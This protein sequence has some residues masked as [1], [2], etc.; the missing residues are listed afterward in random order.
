MSLRPLTLVGMII[1]IV[2]GIALGVLVH[3]RVPHEPSPAAD[4]LD[5]VLRQVA[6]NYVEEV[7]EEELLERAIEGMMQ[8]LDRHS[9]YL[10]RDSVESLEATT[11]GQFGGIGIELGFVDGHYTIISPMDFTPAARVGLRSGDRITH[12]EGDTVT[13]MKMPALVERLRGE[14][15]SAVKLTIEREGY[16]GREFEIEREVIRVA[17]VNTRLLEPGYGY[18]RISQFQT[19]TGEDVRKA[20]ETFTDEDDLKGLVLD[21]R[22]NPGGTLHSSVEVSDHFLESGLI[23]YTQGRLKSSHV[24]YRATRGDLLDGLPIVVLINGGSASASEIVAASLRDHKR[25]TLMGTKS[26]GKGSVQSVL[27]LD[28]TQALKLTTAYYYTPNGHTI[29]ESGIEPDLHFEGADEELLDEAVQ[30]L[31]RQGATSLQ[32]RLN[33]S[34]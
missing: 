17:S 29:H 34:G 9:N 10:D 27:P 24:K 23:V 7:S 26:Y 11:T 16:A 15:G 4:T 8:G 33:E 20:I 32:A 18:L 21:L 30:F 19:S 25:A 22:N 3:T 1:S 12:I 28:D 5:Q 6:D 14:P 2:T 31:K 13:G